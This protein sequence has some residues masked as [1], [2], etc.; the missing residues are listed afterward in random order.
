[1]R[2]VGREELLVWTWEA[3]TMGLTIGFVYLEVGDGLTRWKNG[4]RCGQPG[5]YLWSGAR[6]GVMIRFTACSIRNWL[7]LCLTDGS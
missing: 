1:M 4:D 7:F 5:I 3:A 2:A 6:V